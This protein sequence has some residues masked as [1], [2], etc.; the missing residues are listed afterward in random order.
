MR[1]LL[2]HGIGQ[3][4]KKKEELA[5]TWTDTL[6]KGYENAKLEYPATLSVDFPYYGDALD[7]RVARS[8]LP[9][10][11]Q[12]VPKGDEALSPYEDFVRCSLADM[13]EIA[14]LSDADVAAEAG[15]IPA[16]E[17]GIQNWR[18]TQAIARL[19]DKRLT[20]F[21]SHT[22]ETFLREVYLYVNNRSA[23]RE[24]NEIVAEMLTDEPTIVIGHSLGSVVAYKVLLEQAAKVKLRRYITVGSPLGI[25]TISSRLGV[26]KYP[27]ADLNWY[28]AYDDGDIVALNPLADPW[29]KT[30]PAITNY[31]RVRNDTDNQ[32]GI[33]GYL[34][35]IMVARSVAEAV[36]G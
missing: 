5:K 33:I 8:K 11:Q 6:R 34:N 20:A 18:L 22:I 12:I 23:A 14:K 17:K 1:L 36:A 7:A 19:L 31:N 35:D 15:P 10:P 9:L 28:N 32:H 26:L 4:G 16:T 3:G 25:K 13:K 21:T 30:D 24:V 27:Q 2:V 29:F